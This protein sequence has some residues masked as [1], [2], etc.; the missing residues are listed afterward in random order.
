MDAIAMRGIIRRLV[1]DYEVR[2]LTGV[3]WLTCIAEREVP[4]GT[5]MRVSAL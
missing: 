4:A 2:T 5:R 1:G 3:S